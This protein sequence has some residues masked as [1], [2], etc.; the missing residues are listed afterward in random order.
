MYNAVEIQKPIR[1]DNPKRIERLLDDL[2]CGACAFAFYFSGKP[3]KS[4]GGTVVLPQYLLLI[5]TG[6]VSPQWSDYQ[7]IKFYFKIKNTGFLFNKYRNTGIG[8]KIP[9][10]STH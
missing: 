9:F 10:P 1:I 4:G 6:V 8:I 5:I 3:T 7:M 2:T